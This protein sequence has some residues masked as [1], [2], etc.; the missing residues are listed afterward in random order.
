MTTGPQGQRV[1][2]EERIADILS[3]YGETDIVAQAIH[4][5]T[6]QL[7]QAVEHTQELLRS[8]NL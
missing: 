3:R 6:P 2:F 5:A 4:Q 7:W 1:S 8:H